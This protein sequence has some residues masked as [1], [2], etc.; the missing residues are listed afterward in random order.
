VVDI[1]TSQKDALFQQI[2]AEQKR[3]PSEQERLTASLKSLTAES[4]LL[5][6]QITMQNQ[7]ILLGQSLLAV[8]TT[9]A[10][11]GLMSETE[12]GHRHQALLDDTQKLAAMAQ[13]QTS[14]QDRI[15]EVRSSLQ[16]LA[17]ITATKLQPLRSELSSL[18]QRIAELV[19]RRGY[20]VRAP[21]TG[22]VSLL[23]VNVGQPADPRRLEMEIVPANFNLQAVLFVPARA[24][25]FIDVGQQVR[26]LYDAFPYEKY[27]THG[28]HILEV[29]QTV[30]NS[31]DVSGPVAL[32]EPSYRAIVALDETVLK[33][34]DGRTVNLQPDT[35]LRADIIL[36][37]RTIMD[38]I[39]KPLL[40]ARM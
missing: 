21:I 9:L 30:L 29:S 23:Q 8:A 36:E 7:R 14:L 25:G 35:L 12:R 32:K 22:R 6:S 15:N 20:V 1:L 28:G 11:K 37:R 40:G 34:R 3:L 24:A 18:E 19:G 27:G 4:A 16:Q 31:T 17:T 2:L 13:Q 39:L 26:L 38:W 5:S 33:T 10:A